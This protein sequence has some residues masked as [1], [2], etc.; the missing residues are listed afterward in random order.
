[1]A[2]YYNGKV[3][4]SDLAPGLNDAAD[5]LLEKTSEVE[6]FLA[7]K[8]T[9]V[10]YLKKR[11]DSIQAELARAQEA[12]NYAE[13]ILTDASEILEEAKELTSEL[14][15]ALSTSGIYHFNYVGKADDLGTYLSLSSMNDLIPSED[16]DFEADESIAAAIIIVGTDDGVVNTAARISRLFQ[17]IG[18]NGAEIASL[19]TSD[20]GE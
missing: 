2:L 7:D 5:H 13:Q 1:M 14:A 6:S 9:H 19:Y 10:N 20:A 4:F 15:D 16:G 3:S 18:G 11:V 17:Q 12:S 8:Q